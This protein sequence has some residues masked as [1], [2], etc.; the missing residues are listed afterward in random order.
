MRLQRAIQW[1]SERLEEQPGADRGKLVDEAAET[2][3]LSPRQEEFLYHIYCQ[4]V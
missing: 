2:F 1:V 3:G 4:P